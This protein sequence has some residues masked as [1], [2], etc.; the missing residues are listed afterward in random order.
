MPR[1]K[2]GRSY[3]VGIQVMYDVRGTV[4]GIDVGTTDT[5]KVEC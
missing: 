1:L 2:T 3:K 4:S 5:F